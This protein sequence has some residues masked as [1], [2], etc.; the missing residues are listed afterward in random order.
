MSASG[1]GTMPTG[2]PVRPRSIRVFV[3]AEGIVVDNGTTKWSPNTGYR[4]KVWAVAGGNVAFVIENRDS[5][6]HHVQIPIGKF[7]PS[8]T[9]RDATPEPLELEQIDKV[10]VKAGEVDV[11][12]LK[13]RQTDHF[14]WNERDPWKSKREIGMTYKYW[15]YTE[16]AD[17]TQIPP[18]DP[19]LE[20]NQ[21]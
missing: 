5:R 13:V 1:L 3:S 19:D 17:G 4:E 20:I 21:P 9:F 11:I 16:P 15:I 7:E 2:V 18:L 6:T 10:D 8:P 12:K 14:K